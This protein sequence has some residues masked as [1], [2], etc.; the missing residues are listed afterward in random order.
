MGEV[1]TVA[2]GSQLIIHGEMDLKLKIGE[3]EY[4]LK[5]KV[6]NIIDEEISS[7]G[8]SFIYERASIPIR[9][10]IIISLKHV[11]YWYTEF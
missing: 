4:G 2:N 3:R 11:Y 8:S 5:V 10:N 1:A 9:G 6:A 7:K